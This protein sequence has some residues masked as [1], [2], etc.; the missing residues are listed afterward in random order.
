MLMISDEM[1]RRIAA[2]NRRDLKHADEVAEAEAQV[3]PEVRP[4]RGERRA[5]DPGELR[6]M[7]TASDARLHLALDEVTQ[8][9]V[10]HTPAGTFLLIDQTVQEFLSG[11]GRAFGARYERAISALHAGNVPHDPYDTF[12]TLI[13]ARAEDVIYVDIETTG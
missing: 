5:P 12:H 13:D 11:G 7:A 10:I 1:R 8:G 2:L 6:V 3:E 4:V 9:E